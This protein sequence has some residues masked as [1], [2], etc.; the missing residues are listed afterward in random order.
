[1][2]PLLSFDEADHSEDRS[3]D[4]TV[5]P[6]TVERLLAYQTPRR[7][8]RQSNPEIRQSFEFLSSVLLP[9]S[10]YLASSA[11]NHLQKRRKTLL[12]LVSPQCPSLESSYFH[13]RL[14][15]VW[16]Y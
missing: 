9:G 7:E 4:T 11:P 10:C 6:T 14:F 13:I 5:G 1:M 8:L 15:W 16:D 2:S 3:E 12:L